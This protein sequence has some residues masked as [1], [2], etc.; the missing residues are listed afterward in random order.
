MFQKTLKDKLVNFRAPVH[1]IR[2]SISSLG[3]CCLNGTGELKQP[4]MHIISKYCLSGNP[5]SGLGL[6]IKI[7]GLMRR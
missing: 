1:L 2:F 7:K 5:F 4:S 3:G 6:P